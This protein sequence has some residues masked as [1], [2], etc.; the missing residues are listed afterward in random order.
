MD[1][2]KIIRFARSGLERIEGP[3]GGVA[4]RCAAVLNDG[5]HLPCV[6]LASVEVILNLARRRFDEMLMDSRLPESKRK[7]KQWH[8]MRTG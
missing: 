2:T 8:M 7:G 5:L 4:F 1:D 6:L 3:Y